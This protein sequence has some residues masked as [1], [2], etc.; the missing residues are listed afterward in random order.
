MTQPMDHATCSQLLRAYVTGDAGA[1]APAVEA[2]LQKCAQCRAERA[3]LEMLLVPLEPLSTPERARLHTSVR[4]AT[5]VG[6]SDSP[7][8]LRT[9]PAVQRQPPSNWHTGDAATAGA[10]R[11]QR[12]RW[13]T[14]A[15][16]AAAAVVL[17]AS[18]I[19]LFGHLGTVSNN[20]ASVSADRG[21]AGGASR[22]QAEQVPAPGL[23]LPVFARARLR[24]RDV[25][26]A[27][28]RSYRRGDQAHRIASG[29]LGPD[30]LVQL[31]DEAPRGLRPQILRCGR[32]AV[33]RNASLV[34]AFGAAATVRGDK[35]LV[36]V[37]VLSRSA[38]RRPI[39]FELVAWPSGSCWPL[40][41]RSG[42]IGR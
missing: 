20:A 25:L 27:F 4:E 6:L 13:L 1:Y 2:H 36:V 38:E 12:L 34:P 8:S 33:H 41:Q 42:S 37:F 5:G 10:V 16:S 35:A 24:A 14:P 22:P 31:A 11:G 40:L 28:K 29:L 32:R 26:A 30:L 21:A 9:I 39:G 7:P 18:G 23:R 15:L 17:I 3:G 19:V